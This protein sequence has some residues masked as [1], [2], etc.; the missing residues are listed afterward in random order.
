M[1]GACSIPAETHASVVCRNV[2]VTGIFIDASSISLYH[3]T[4]YVHCIVA[5]IVANIV[6]IIIVV[7]VVTYTLCALCALLV[8]DV[9]LS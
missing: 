7:V 4:Y 9:F 8:C 1:C 5:V 6:I 3:V 2:A